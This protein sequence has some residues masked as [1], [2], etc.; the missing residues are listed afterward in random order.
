MIKIIIFSLIIITIILIVSDFVYK[1]DTFINTCKITLPEFSFTNDVNKNIIVK[2]IFNK[3][4]MMSN[5]CNTSNPTNI[6]LMLGTYK[7]LIL[8]NEDEKYLINPELLTLSNSNENIVTEIKLHIREGYKLIVTTTDN[9]TTEFNTTD[10]KE[11]NDI[12]NAFK[13]VSEISV[14]AL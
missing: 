2:I 13:N 3:G 6:S 14:K 8:P 1:M 10:K 12:I 11:S 4:M 9:K 7:K 5:K